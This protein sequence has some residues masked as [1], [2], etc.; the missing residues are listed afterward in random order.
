MPKRLNLTKN[1]EALKPSGGRLRRWARNSELAE[2]LGISK[3]TL[4]RFKHNQKFKLPPAAVINN[5]EFNDL[6]KIDKWMEA[7]VAE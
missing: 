2:Y 7:R 6:D 1:A 3:M 5:I 4:W